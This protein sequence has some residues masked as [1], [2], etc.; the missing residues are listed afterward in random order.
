MTQRQ[1]MNFVSRLH[2]VV[3]WPETPAESRQLYWE[4][5]RRLL[6]R[7]RKVLAVSAAQK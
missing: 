5:P 6:L 1:W 3:F 7:Q 4:I 2:P